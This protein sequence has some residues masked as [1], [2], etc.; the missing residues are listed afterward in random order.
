MDYTMQLDTLWVLLGAALVFFMQAGFAMVETGFTR[1]KNAGNIIMKNLMDFAFG[2]VVF[3]LIGF[4][5]LAGSK[6]GFWGGIDFFIR[7]TYD[8]GTI[9]LWAYVAFNTVFC[10]TA[11]TIV[12]GAMAE[13]TKFS[14]YLVYSVV[15][16]AVVYPISAHWVWGGGWLSSLS[17][18][19]ATGFVDYAGS[20]LVHMCGGIAALIGAKIL[21]PRIGKF[22]KNGK[23]RAI[24]GH[25]LTLGALGVMI[26]WFGWFG[27]NPASS[28]GLS[29]IEN[30]LDVS[31]VFMTTNI[32]AAASTV[33]AMIITWIKYKKPDVSM[34]LNGSLAG[35]VAITAGCSV[36]DPWAATIIGIIAGF[37][38]VFGIEFIEKVCKIDDPV[39]AIGVH[40]LCGAF[41]TLA[42]GLFAREN[43][44]FTT[45]QW[46]QFV[47]QLIGVLAIAAWVTVTMIITFTIIKKTM[48]LRASVEEEVL[49]LDITEHG[50]VSAYAD[51]TA[52][53][54]EI[55]VDEPLAAEV[56]GNVP[57]DEA[58]PV[59]VK[60]APPV[61]SD[62]SGLR[63]TKVEIICKQSR[64]DALKTAMSRIGIT[65]MTVTHV[66]GY[67]IQKGKPEFY[68]GA[69]IESS[70]LPKVQ[71]EIVVCKV[72]V[73]TVIDTAKKVLYTGHIGD[74]KI[75][76]YNIENVIK[77]RT[78]EEGYD[79]LQDVE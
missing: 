1:A 78:G 62:E 46:G 28:Y 77:V 56:T 12:S 6:N 49:G 42:V 34:T 37:V 4:G 31:N 63:F 45:G 55:Y 27:F 51:F 33:T 32:A 66:L 60:A 44:L 58:L 73:K 53:V 76:I 19:G 74:G 57:V 39:G 48:G 7:G 59:Q 75:F 40:C 11:A 16:S 65:G 54:E 68:R 14:A 22:D 79:A 71:V 5:I 9:P 47:I 38:V 23:P 70:L 21:G 13:R 61:A 10:A 41:G 3:Y 25:S 50:L 52:S 15:I 24:P 29:S 67:G 8:T 36:V 2:S 18:G 43:G 72:P 26:L 69:E 20:A 17:I 30:A 35:L 64:F